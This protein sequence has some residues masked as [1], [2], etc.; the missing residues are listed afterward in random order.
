MEISTYLDKLHSSKIRA[1]LLLAP[2]TET[3]LQ[4]QEY[5]MTHGFI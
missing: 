4:D 1:I 2:A 3:R 5:S